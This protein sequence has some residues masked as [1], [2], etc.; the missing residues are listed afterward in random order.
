[1][2]LNGPDLHWGSVCLCGWY[3]LGE[4]G[5]WLWRVMFQSVKQGAGAICLGR[6][7]GDMEVRGRWL[8]KVTV[9]LFPPARGW[10]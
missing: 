8:Q 3:K 9:P 4:P 2:H 7:I 1:M 6:Y 10:P 5:S